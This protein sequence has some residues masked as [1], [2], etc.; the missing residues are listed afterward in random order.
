MIEKCY[1][2]LPSTELF[3]VKYLLKLHLVLFSVQHRLSHCD[4]W[5]SGLCAIFYDIRQL[6]NIYVKCK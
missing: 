5:Q 2:S 1:V 6:K 4:L 3:G